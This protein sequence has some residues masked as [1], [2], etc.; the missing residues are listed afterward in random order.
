M[1]EENEIV[2][3]PICSTSHLIFRRETMEVTEKKILEKTMIFSKS[4]YII[5]HKNH[6]FIDYPNFKQ[7]HSSNL[8]DEYVYYLMNLINEC[9][10]YYSCF[11]IHINMQSFTIT[12]AQKYKGMI[13]KFLQLTTVPE[14]MNRL[15][16]IY[17]YK[18]PKMIDGIVQ[19][20]SAFFSDEKLKGKVTI[21]Q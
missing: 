19:F 10:Q 3:R 16:G 5:P 11:E 12:A 14:L 7:F 18:I 4:A 8:S 17:L 1:Q 15:T 6:L 9:L 20:F 2:E 13:Y 21:V